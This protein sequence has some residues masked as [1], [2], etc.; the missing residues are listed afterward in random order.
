MQRGRRWENSQ[1]AL[2]LAQLGQP[3]K[4]PWRNIKPQPILSYPPCLSK[5]SL[6]MYIPQSVNATARQG[7]N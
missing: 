6:A 7:V 4:G 5:V 3:Q 2:G 1:Q